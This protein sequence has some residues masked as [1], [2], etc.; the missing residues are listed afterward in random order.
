MYCVMILEICPMTGQSSLREERKILCFLKDASATDRLP[1]GL[2]RKHLLLK[3]YINY[4]KKGG[5]YELFKI[6]QITVSVAG[7]KCHL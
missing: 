3:N 6:L 7:K 1:T 4:Y 2:Q 5:K